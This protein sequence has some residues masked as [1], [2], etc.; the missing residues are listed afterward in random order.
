MVYN[1]SSSLLLTYHQLCA[2]FFGLVMPPKRTRQ[3]KHPH[4]APRRELHDS[5]QLESD[6]TTKIRRRKRNPDSEPGR[7]M[8]LLNPSFSYI[9]NCVHLFLSGHAPKTYTLT[10]TSSYSPSS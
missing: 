3:P 1:F 2:P 8:I 4:I 7:F 5:H 10:K 6:S 9:I